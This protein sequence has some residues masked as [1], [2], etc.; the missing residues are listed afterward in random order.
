MTSDPTFIMEPSGEGEI[1]SDG[2]TWLLDLVAAADHLRRGARPGI[3]VW[4]AITEAVR[5]THVG[6]S[7]PAPDIPHRSAAIPGVPWSGMT[8]GSAEFLQ[9]AIR[10]WVLVMAHRYNDGHHWPHPATRRPFPPPLV[11]QTLI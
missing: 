11:D 1:L 10:R 8:D 7:D 4:D 9:V 5:W 2:G 3:T 6:P